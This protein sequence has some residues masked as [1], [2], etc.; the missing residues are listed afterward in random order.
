M[1]GAF[2]LKI[3]DEEELIDEAVDELERSGLL[4]NED[5]FRRACRDRDY[6]STED[7]SSNE[8]ADLQQM[9][10]AKAQ[11]E[12]S[13]K[14]TWLLNEE[15]R[16]FLKDHTMW[17]LAAGFFFVSGPGEAFLTNLGTIIGTLYPPTLDSSAI[18]TSAA[19]HV[20][21]VAFTSTVA[22]IVFGLLTDFLAPP[23][24][25]HHYQSASNS[26][27]SLPPKKRFSVSRI[28]FLLLSAVLLI[29]GQVLLASGFIQN[30]GERFWIVS[31]LIGSGYG[32]LF[33]LTPLIITVIWGV[34]NFGTNWGIV[35]MVPAAGATVWGII[36]STVYQK[37]AENSVVSH[38][39]ADELLC[40]GKQCYETTFWAM[41]LSVSIGCGLWMWAWKGRG[42][43]SSR[44]ISV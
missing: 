30:H 16:R 31:T 8:A 22:R 13:R 14:K 15:T 28:V 38:D 26:L 12:E 5:F 24:L 37:G 39:E 25:G 20:S 1:I 4:P 35:A 44:G 27:S 32:A 10:D 11:M 2:L 23:S 43:W 33:S 34:E 21:I 41:A 40:Y 6:G 18:P 3:V 42:G 9:A 29:L 17:W 36:Y 19:T 7:I